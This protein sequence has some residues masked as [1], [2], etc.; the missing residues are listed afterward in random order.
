MG[1]S[2][3]G[4][5]RL[6]FWG[7]L[8]STQVSF[9]NLI[10]WKPRNLLEKPTMVRSF[11]CKLGWTESPKASNAFGFKCL[12]RAQ[13]SVFTCWWNKLTEMGVSVFNLWMGEGNG[14]VCCGKTGCLLWF[15]IRLPQRSLTCTFLEGWKSYVP[16]VPAFFILE[17]VW[18]WI[19]CGLRFGFQTGGRRCESL[20]LAGNQRKP[21]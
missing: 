16:G 5:I 7:N 11:I 2:F 12:G 9:S 6:N 18:R 20:R 1:F 15:P 8:I 21:G 4:F 10:Q 13:R 14:K 3:E 19:S 17:Q